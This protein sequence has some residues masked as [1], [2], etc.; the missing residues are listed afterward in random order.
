MKSR[1]TGNSVIQSTSFEKR[2]KDKWPAQPRK[3]TVLMVMGWSFEKIERFC[4]ISLRNC[5]F[6]LRLTKKTMKNVILQV[7]TTIIVIFLRFSSDFSSRIATFDFRVLF[8][9][10]SPQVSCSYTLFPEKRPKFQKTAEKT[11]FSQWKT[12]FR[13]F[14]DKKSDEC[15]WFFDLYSSRQQITSDFCK[16]WWF[17]LVFQEN[18]LGSNFSDMSTKCLESGNMCESWTVWRMG[19]L[20]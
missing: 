10:T 19:P 8:G 14:R 9:S 20:Q 4:G 13:I 16:I 6:W 2:E 15:V 17:P 7:F 12:G 1:G 18:S 5:D 3:M 11:K